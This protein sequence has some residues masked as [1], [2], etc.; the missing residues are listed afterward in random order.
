[1]DYD[2]SLPAQWVKTAIPVR[3]TC[4]LRGCSN[5]FFALDVCVIVHMICATLF[6]IFRAVTHNWTYCAEMRMPFDSILRSVSFFGKLS[7]H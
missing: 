3:I 1:M 2:L 6:L 7:S 5:S 4:E